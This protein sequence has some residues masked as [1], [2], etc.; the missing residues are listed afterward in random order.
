MTNLK[1]K[2]YYDQY[3]VKES[4]KESFI[5]LALYTFNATPEVVA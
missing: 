3:C 4:F 2:L 1:I 5:V